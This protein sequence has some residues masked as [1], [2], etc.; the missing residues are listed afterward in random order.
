[1]AYCSKT[2]QKIAAA[3]ANAAFANFAEDSTGV[4]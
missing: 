1:L 4:I 2:R 3:Q